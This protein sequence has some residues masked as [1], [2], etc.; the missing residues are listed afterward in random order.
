MV[1]VPTRFWSWQIVLLGL[2]H[3]DCKFSKKDGRVSRAIQTSSPTGRL[4]MVA[5]AGGSWIGSRRHTDLY[6]TM[7]EYESCD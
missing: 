2:D 3:L 5:V 1:I 7:S 4:V 6:N